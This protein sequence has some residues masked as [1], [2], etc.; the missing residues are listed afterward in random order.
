MK[1]VAK[2]ETCQIRHVGYVIS[3]RLGFLMDDGVK[4]EVGPGE[5]FDVHPGH[6][7]W[8]IGLVP[9]VF[10]DLISAVEGQ[11]PLEMSKGKNRSFTD[12]R[13]YP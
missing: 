9:A 11:V 2:T 3:G 6:D 12:S 1:P 4:L 10:L 5:A 13:R 8:T 7:S